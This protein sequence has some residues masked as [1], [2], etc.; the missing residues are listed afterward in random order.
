MIFLWAVLAVL[1]EGKQRGG[2]GGE[3]TLPLV[4]RD[5]DVV[6]VLCAV[7]GGSG[8]FWKVVI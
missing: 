3:E 6:R 8:Y 7:A 1:V 4:R 5:I 2:R